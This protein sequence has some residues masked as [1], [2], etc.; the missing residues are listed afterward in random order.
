MVKQGIVIEDY[1]D[2]ILIMYNVGH[3][4]RTDLEDDNYMYLI[5]G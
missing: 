1:Y 5:D 3:Y 4:C 2:I